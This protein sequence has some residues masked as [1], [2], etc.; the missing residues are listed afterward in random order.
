MVLKYPLTQMK[1]IEKIKKLIKKDLEG[2]TRVKFYRRFKNSELCKYNLKVR[3]CL[4][5]LIPQ[6]NVSNFNQTIHY[7]SWY[8]RAFFTKQVCLLRLVYFESKINR[9]FIRWHEPESFITAS[10]VKTSVSFDGSWFHV[11]FI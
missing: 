9:R 10:M 4:H 3:L 5:S 1:T 7:S 6:E 11:K 2:Y 8:T